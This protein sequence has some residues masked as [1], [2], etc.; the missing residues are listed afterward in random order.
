MLKRYLREF[1][2]KSDPLR[3]FYESTRALYHRWRKLSYYVHDAKQTLRFMRWKQGSEAA[4][5]E[6]S[7]ELLFYYHKLEK[8]LCMPGKK[9]FF[10][11]EPASM[12]VGLLK[13]WRVNGFPANDPV[14]LGAIETLRAYRRRIEETPPERGDLLRQKLDEAL[15]SADHCP[16]YATPRPA[17]RKE[18]P[19]LFITFSHLSDIRRSVRDFKPD[20]V[21]QTMLEHAVSVAKA[22]P[23]ACNRQPCR[24]HAFADREEI[25]ALLMFQNGNRGFGHTIPLLLVLTAHANSFFDASERYQPYVDG[26]LFAMSLIYALQAQGLSSCCLNWCV[27]PSVDTKAHIRGNIPE[28]EIIIMYIAVGYAQLDACV[29]RSPRRCTETVLLHH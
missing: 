6:A 11:Y 3:R 29:P 1:M 8:G 16:E 26:G 7:A 22:S 20:P 28:N 17:Y 18:E 4:Y 10:G 24:V 19:E 21:P 15:S 12:V 14:Y 9:R 23:S 13:Q 27:E 2:A 25:D 5:W